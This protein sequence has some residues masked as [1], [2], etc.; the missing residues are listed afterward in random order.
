MNAYLIRCQVPSRRA[1]GEVILQEKCRVGR[2]RVG[3]GSGGTMAA[4]G[5]VGGGWLQG[6]R[7]DLP[8]ELHVWGTAAELFAAELS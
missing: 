3:R 1:G 6:E 7:A 5:R 4:A 2:G 8:G